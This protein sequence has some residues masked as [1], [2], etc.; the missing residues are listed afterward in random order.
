MKFEHTRIFN[1]EGA[2]RGMRNPYDSW[3]RADSSFGYFEFEPDD[4]G[5]EVAGTY[6][7]KWDEWATKGDKEAEKEIDEK[8][9]YLIEQG[10]HFY[11]DT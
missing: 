5:W 11:D 4:D 8:Q 3:N 2:F 6:S 7:D 9:Q 10:V 1:F